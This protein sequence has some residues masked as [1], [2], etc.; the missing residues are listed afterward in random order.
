M[1]TFL[2]ICVFVSDYKHQCF[3]P[4]CSLMRNQCT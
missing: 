4:V 1:K 3:M 2:P